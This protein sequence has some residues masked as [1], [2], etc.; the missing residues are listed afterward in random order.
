[1]TYKNTKDH[2]TQTTPEQRQGTT[3]MEGRKF[4]DNEHRTPGRTV[5]MRGVEQNTSHTLKNQEECACDDVNLH[6]MSG[7]SDG[8]R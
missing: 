1:M 7:S 3:P 5:R 2:Y 4:P 6:P 8:T